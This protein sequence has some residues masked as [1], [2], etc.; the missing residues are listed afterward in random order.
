MIIEKILEHFGDGVGVG[1]DIGCQFATTLRRSSLAVRAKAQNLTMLVGAFHGYGHNRSCQ[2]ENLALYKNGLGR[3]PL[4]GCEIFFNR[5]NRLAGPMRN[6]GTFTRH[7][8]IAEFLSQ[9]DRIEVYRGLSALLSS[10]WKGAAAILE[11]EP[12]LLTEMNRLGIANGAV[13]VAWLAEERELLKSRT[14][15][16]VGESLEMGYVK[17]LLEY[18]TASVAFH[19]IRNE[20][21]VVE[22]AAFAA[23]GELSADN[24]LSLERARHRLAEKRQLCLHTVHDLEAKLCIHV[25]DRWVPGQREWVQAMDLIDKRVYHKAIDRLEGLLVA[26]LSELA[27]MNMAMTGKLL[28]LQ[29]YFDY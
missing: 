18:N 11:D 17:A 4:E 23:T 7:Q 12:F 14:K 3:E 10:K 1:Y 29:G 8:V 9:S 15:E 5:S 22:P 6:M 24:T 27:K 20:W 2:T 21:K 19:N 26:R 16:D 28:F 25:D 13:F